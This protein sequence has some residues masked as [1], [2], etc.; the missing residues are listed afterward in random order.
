M[1]IVK[2]EAI[3][4]AYAEPNDFGATRR[5]S[6]VKLTADDG[7]TGWGEA[8]TTWE[9]AT[10]ATCRLIE[11]LG[12]LVAGKDPVSSDAIWRELQ[13]QTGWYGQGGLACYAISALDMAVWDLKGKALGEPLV[14]LLGGRITDRVPAIVSAHAVKANLEEM[15]EEI[16]S[17]LEPG[18]HGYKFGLGTKGD[19]DLGT[20]H[21]R[22]V[23]FVR[24]LREA[25]GPDKEIMVDA[26]WGYGIRWDFATALRRIEAFDEQ[27]IRWIE[28]PL[29]PRDLASYRRLRQRVRTLLAVG[30][31]EWNVSGYERLIASGAA[32][33]IGVD[34]GRVE[35]VTGTRKIVERIEAG[36]CHFN[37]HTWSSAINSAVS[38]AISV[39]TP[40]CLYYEW[41]PISNP[42]QH[43]LVAEP[44]DPVDGW[45][46]PPERPGLGIEVVEEVVDHYRIDR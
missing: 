1:K 28:E 16:A 38:I 20:D 35:G 11:G 22:D 45:M 17:W 3:P 18:L 5:L 12:D 26:I 32:S 33:V 29:D 31:R 14:R 13:Q 15:I 21:E 24:G 42:M 44:L 34:P 8:V 19:A 10:A 46:V 9:E 39:T 7:Q 2:V 6:L 40:T 23:S 27:R 25:L 4:V 43:E 30:E 36:H 37:A 41:K